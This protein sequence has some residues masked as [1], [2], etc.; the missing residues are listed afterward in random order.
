MN[1]F[2]GKPS[3]RI[4]TYYFVDDLDKNVSIIEQLIKIVD[5]LNEPD[6]DTQENLCNDQRENLRI[7]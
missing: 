1:F 2:I 3:K 5:K 6:I 7:E 4:Y